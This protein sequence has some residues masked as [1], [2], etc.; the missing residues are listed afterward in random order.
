[1]T[2]IEDA[3]K[4]GE[5]LKEMITEGHQLLKDIKTERR[6][7]EELLKEIP[8]LIEKHVGDKIDRAVR[9]GLE[10]FSQSAQK[11]MRESVKKVSNEFQK[12][13]NLLLTGDE[14]GKGRPLDQIVRR[15]LAAE[16]QERGL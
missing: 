15:R 4:T 1:M 13:Q 14:E 8:N 6:A 9:L 3:Q 12:L 11:A 7:L 10:Q 5:Q 16:Q 2:W